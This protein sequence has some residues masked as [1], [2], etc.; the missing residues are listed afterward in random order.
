MRG[1]LLALLNDRTF[2]VLIILGLVLQLITLYL[3]LNWFGLDPVVIKISV[4][5]YLFNLVLSAV[6][7]SQFRAYSYVLLATPILL[8]AISYG[9]VFSLR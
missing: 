8:L 7:Y 9:I 6:S 5:I 1:L 4:G 2:L 3:W